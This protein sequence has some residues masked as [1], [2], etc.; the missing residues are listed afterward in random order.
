VYHAIWSA[1]H[2]TGGSVNVVLSRLPYTPTEGVI[3]AMGRADSYS[4]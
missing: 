1:I 2:V 3:S 4:L